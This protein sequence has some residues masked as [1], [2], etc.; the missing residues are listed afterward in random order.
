MRSPGL[1]YLLSGSLVLLGLSVIFGWV[2]HEP[3]LIRMGTEFDSMPPST[4]I[5]FLLSGI[6]L[7]TAA[8]RSSGHPEYPP[9]LQNNLSWAKRLSAILPLL[10]I[11]LGLLALI[12]W[13]T[14]ITIGLTANLQTVHSWL[15]DS[16]P[17]LGRMRPLAAVGFISLGLAIKLA[18][19][20]FNPLA[21]LIANGLALL[22]MFLGFLGVVGD[23]AGFETV[24]SWDLGLAFF[25]G[26]GFMT[27]SLGL[28]ALLYQRSLHQL[29]WGRE[30]GSRIGLLAGGITIITG[31]SGILG[32]FAILY[33]QAI[34]GLEN[35]LALSLKS[36]VDTLEIT[37]QQGWLDS[38]SFGNQPL[39]IEAM[40]K[41]DNDPKNAH[42]RNEMQKVAERYRAFGFS[43]VKFRATNGVEVAHAGAF[44]T[45]PELSVTIKTPTPSKLQWQEG[46]VLHTHIDMIDKGIIVGSMEVERQ[47]PVGNKLHDTAHFGDTMDFAVCAQANRNLECFPFRSTHGKVLHNLPTEFG[48]KP[49]PVYFALTGKTGIVHTTDY[50]GTQVIAA[51]Q[52]VGSLGLGA[53]LKVDAEDL[54]SPIRQ[55]LLPMLFM[56]LCLGSF[57]MVLLRL[58]FIPM[59]RK[60][61]SEVDA[62][63]KT[64]AQLEQSR[65]ELAEITSNLG[66]GVY[67]LDEQ[68]IVTFINPVAER[69]LGW[70]ASEI[71]GQKGHEIFHFKGADGAAVAYDNCIGHQTLKTGQTYRDLSNIFV[72]KDGSFIPV[73]IVS[74][75]I[76]RNGKIRGAIVSFD[77]ITQ[78][79]ALDQSLRESEER[80]RNFFEKNRSVMLLTDTETGHIV[81]ANPAAAEFY[82]YPSEML[83][84]MHISDIEF[85]PSDESGKDKLAQ[86]DE[87]NCF[88]SQHRLASA[89]VREVEIYSSPVLVNNKMVRFSIVHDITDRKQAEQAQLRLNRAFRLLSSGNE[90]L[91]HAENEQKLLSD[92][93]R[94][95]VEIGDYLMAWVG[96]AVQDE[97]KT[98]RPVAESGYEKDYL[99]KITI[100]WADTDTG[101][102]PTGTAIR[103]G[104]TQINQNCLINPLMAPWREAALQRGYQA[105]IALPLV[106]EKEA[107]GA[108]TIYSSI[109]EAFNEDE[110]KLLQKLADG[111]SFGI[112]TL[113]SA[114]IRQKAETELRQSEERYRLV[115]ENAADAV[116]IINPEKRFVYAN[117]Q[118]T[119]MLGYSVDDLLALSVFDILPPEEKQRAQDV[120]DQLEE[121]TDLRFEIRLKRDDN[122]T[123]P[124]EIN[125]VM[126]PDG[127]FFGACR[128]ITERKNY[129]SRLEYQATH[130]AL[131]G[132]ANRNLLTDRIEQSIAHAHRSGKSVA[133]IMLDLD[134]FKLIND[135]LGHATGDTL[136]QEIAKRLSNCV[137]SGDTVARLG[138]DEFMIAIPD[139]VSEDGVGTLSRNILNVVAKPMS[140][141]G[142]EM[143]ITASLGVAIYPRDGE[144]VPTLFKNADIAMYRAKELGRN[145][146]QFYAPEMNSRMLGRLELE[147]GLRRALENGELAL[148]YQPKVDLRHGNMVGAEALIRWNHPVAGIVSPGDFIP[149]AEETGLIVPIGEWVIETACKQIKTWQD[150]GLPDITVA[151][152]LS[153]RQFQQENLIQVVEQGLKMSGIQARHLELEVTESSVMVN[154]EKTIAILHDL[155]RIGVKIA[156]DDF[157]TG[158]SSLNYLKRF[159]IDSL[160]IDQSFVRDIIS[161]PD[162]AA[163]AKLVISLAHSLKQ[164]V[165]A[166]GVEN[167]AQLR[168]LQRNQ[169]DEMQGYFFSRPLP[170]EEFASLLFK[171]KRLE[172]AV[173]VQEVTRTILIV[174][175]EA[176][177]ISSIKRLL[178]PEGYHILT[179]TSAAEGLKLLALH[180]V[181]VIISDQR[182][183]QMNGTDFLNLVWQMYPDT[184][185]IL[186]T[187]YTDLKS[188][189][190]AVNKGAILKFL[191]KPWDD[192]QL[193][194]HVREAF[195]YYES[196]EK[197]SC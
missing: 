170:A 57:A 55:K 114:A 63:R 83:I 44:I 29:N 111:L 36:R 80:F 185:R 35:N 72:R 60:L 189:T 95:I 7:I 16:N 32:G 110:V 191:T 125:A 65:T 6:A 107:F 187:G 15:S 155:K 172:L 10:L 54:Y 73:S 3:N 196:T 176:H 184:I 52:P 61:T 156:L 149:L 77:D 28:L 143:V 115:L 178:R 169:C 37:I 116:I 157:G 160:K 120:I 48:G 31:L 174:D 23:F 92:I 42:E 79:L 17:Y 113:R 121:V 168:F 182:M 68:G 24:F 78:R 126:L 43:G 106:D 159:P 58:Q 76:V 49:I 197:S 20:V 164:T 86:Q 69:L 18:T 89:E 1:V 142:N 4:A 99:E 46:F 165:I 133:V 137:R 190:E 85:H 138:G 14:N 66:E 105:S 27:A 195:R 193:K 162:D 102:G 59:V 103:T 93:C 82:G 25:A 171:D 39:R 140:V 34:G 38:Y 90:L 8:I 87:R 119:Q 75:P 50:R 154:P 33:P 117:K 88:S 97:S 131:T 177:I 51:H 180:T 11:L 146:F 41:L 186:L 167:E 132:L 62:R 181:Q 124:V 5:G 74:S 153:A 47:L 40:K 158:Y 67:V 84:G 145:S 101:R 64:E 53:V 173:E 148:Y 123:V 108:L 26:I 70:T 175:D 152:N 194:E 188:V 91:V 100:S 179:A 150:Q 122:S 135:T 166:E 9:S 139:V 151:V 144:L 98:V 56:L 127:N 183:P 22:T 104:I 118:T 71:I 128:D 141:A 109:P 94:Q 45:A 12:E 19:R 136:L 21:I 112:L 161:D 96:F 192:E 2:I 30:D 147:N 130:D 129:E 13:Q 163:I 134:R 81:D